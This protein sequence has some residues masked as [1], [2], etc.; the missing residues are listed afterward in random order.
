M[1]TGHCP[2]LL[3]QPLPQASVMD[4]KNKRDYASKVRDVMTRGKEWTG[5]E[6]QLDKNSKG[7]SGDN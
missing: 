5:V 2:F 3:V 7:Y 6:S 4:R 1:T